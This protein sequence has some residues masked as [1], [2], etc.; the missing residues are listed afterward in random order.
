MGD[1]DPLFVAP[2][3]GDYSLQNGSPALSKLH[4]QPIGAIDPMVPHVED[5]GARRC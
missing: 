2:N 1:A 3:R 5:V 4:F